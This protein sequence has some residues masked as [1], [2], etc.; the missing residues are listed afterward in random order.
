MIGIYGGF[1][2]TLILLLAFRRTGTQRLGTRFT[3]TLLG[4]MFASMAVDGMNS[5]LAEFGLAHLYTPT[6]PLR[7]LTGLLS[8]IA[9][10]AVLVW[11]LGIVALPR[12]A[13]LRP[14]LIQSP[15]ELAAPLALNASFAALVMSGHPALY[16]P[17]AFIG[18]TG[19]LAAMGGAALLIMLKVSGLDGKVL[20]RRQLLVP[21][22]WALLLVVLVLTSTALARWTITPQLQRERAALYTPCPAIGGTGMQNLA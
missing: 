8:G 9:I 18:V 22:A 12:R 4:L 20:Q 14:A 3:T 2:L 5:T 7:L 11:L 17:L 10:A 6:N 21:S 16:Y 15:W 19:V 1:L 13:R